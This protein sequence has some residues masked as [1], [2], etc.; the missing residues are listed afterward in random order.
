MIIFL[1]SIFYL[2]VRFVCI[3]GSKRIDWKTNKKKKEMEH[4]AAKQ[5]KTLKIFQKKIVQNITNK[6]FP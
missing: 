3:I 5:K 1:F 4:G 6:N 2:S